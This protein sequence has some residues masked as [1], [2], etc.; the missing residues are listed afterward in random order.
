M[1]SDVWEKLPLLLNQLTAVYLLCIMK[2]DD[3]FA[4]V[5]LSDGTLEVKFLHISHI[6]S[7]LGIKGF[8][9]GLKPLL[10]LPEVNGSLA[11]SASLLM[12][13]AYIM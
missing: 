11:I 12:I 1:M 3:D 8:A 10:W 13:E 9:L 6:R 7:T 5:P 2:C 4:T